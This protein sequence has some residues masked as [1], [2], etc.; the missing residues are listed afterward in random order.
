ML[1]RAREPRLPPR[2]ASTPLEQRTRAAIYDVYTAAEA[3]S[4]RPPQLSPLI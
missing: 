2:R 1:P 3:A 4:R